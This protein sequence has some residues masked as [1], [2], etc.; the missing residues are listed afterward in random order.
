MDPVLKERR[1]SLPGGRG[2]AGTRAEAVGWEEVGK[3]ADVHKAKWMA[4]GLV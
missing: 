1:V 4:E 2:R 3:V